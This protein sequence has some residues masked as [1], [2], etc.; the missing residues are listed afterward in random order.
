MAA[1][2][3]LLFAS[4]VS[5]VAFA[6]ISITPA[7]D[8]TIYVGN[9]ITIGQ[10]RIVASGN[11]GSSAALQIDSLSLPSGLTI[12]EGVP[13]PGTRDISGTPAPGTVGGSPYVSTFTDTTDG[14][15]GMLTITVAKGPQTIVCADQTTSVGATVTLAPYSTDNNGNTIDVSQYGLANPGPHQPTY[16]FSGGNATIATIDATGAVTI[17]GPGTTSFTVNSATTDSYEA[18]APLTV[19]FTVNAAPT[20]AGGTLPNGTVNAAYS[21]SIASNA[22]DGTTPYSFALSGG[23]SLPAG[24]SLAAD[25]I[26]SGTPTTA[27]TNHSFAVTLTDASGVTATATFTLTVSTAPVTPTAPTQITPLEPTV[28]AG[29][30][31]TLTADGNPAPTFALDGSQP[32]GV[33]ISLG[34]TLSVAST[35]APGTYT[36]DVTA[37]N[38]EGS[39]SETITLT[40]KAKSSGGGSSDDWE[41]MED[42]KSYEQAIVIK[43]REWANVRSGPSTDT[44]IVGRVYLGESISL[45]QWN[46][47]ETWCKILYDA[48]SKT[49][50]LYYKFIKPVK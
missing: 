14:F 20:L 24:L 37:T 3:V 33:T 21:Q 25:G 35:V 2:L 7:T 47:D 18:A 34:G 12:Q 29:G 5:S 26:I 42:I 6:T 36:F 50:W 9:A 49:G 46:K 41:P 10:L 45:L 44:D 1:F 11:P 15:S 48:D 39:H 32:P 28:T 19:N 22:S 4:S 8:V 38:S 27:V 43:C 17:V 31:T 30:S 16:T 23:S 40:V 13:G